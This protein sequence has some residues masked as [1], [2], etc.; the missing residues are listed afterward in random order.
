MLLVAKAVYKFDCDSE[1]KERV[2]QALSEHPTNIKDGSTRILDWFISQ[3]AA[4]RAAILAKDVVVQRTLAR[5]L[6]AEMAEP[7]GPDLTQIGVDGQTE[8]VPVSGKR[9]SR[10]ATGDRRE[11]R[12]RD[13]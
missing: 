10:P 1:W 13:D 3:S 7:N 5:G 9:G 2:E 6:L 11:A 8:A 4:F 12:I